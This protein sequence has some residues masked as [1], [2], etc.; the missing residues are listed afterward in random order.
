[1]DGSYKEGKPR[2]G[3][4]V[5]HSLTN[6]ITYID[7]SGQEETHTIMIAELAAIHVAL[8]V[9]KHHPWLG[10]FTDSK[11]SIHAIQN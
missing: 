1:M 3:A 11:T 5:I 6:T 7:A 8:T 2:L 10:I 9:H 4:S